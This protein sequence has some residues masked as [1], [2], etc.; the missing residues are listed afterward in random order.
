LGFS[1]QDLL[2]VYDIKEKL[3]YD[4]YQEENLW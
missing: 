3:P 4:W 2:D 1:H